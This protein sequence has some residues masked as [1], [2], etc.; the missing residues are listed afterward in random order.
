MLDHYPFRI[1][2]GARRVDHIS[3]VRRSDRNFR[4][5]FALFRNPFPILINEN[6]PSVAT[7]NIFRQTLLGKHESQ[8]RVI[9][10]EADAI[11]RI[12]GIERNICAA[13][14]QH[15]ENSHQH[16]QRSLDADSHQNFGTDALL[17]QIMRQQIGAVIQF[18]VSQTLA[19]KLRGNGF[20]SSGYLRFEQL[21]EARVLGK[22]NP[23]VIPFNQ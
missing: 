11:A 19:L 20:G 18:A 6:R 12:F 14:F 5:P 16:L 9:N 10:H 4:I 22:F 3:E 2:R 17:L 13:R 1:S 8:L 21:M 7:R 23:R 15:A